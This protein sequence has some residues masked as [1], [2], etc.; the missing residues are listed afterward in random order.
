[1]SLRWSR[2]SWLKASMAGM[3]AAWPASLL[4]GAAGPQSALLGAEARPEIPVA[5]PTPSLLP[6]R[7][8]RR[9][10]L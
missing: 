10:V 9:V 6:D 8:C 5:R 4:F 3:G 2:R 7:L 1:M